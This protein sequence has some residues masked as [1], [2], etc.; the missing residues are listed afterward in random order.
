MS[1]AALDTLAGAYAALDL[2]LEGNNVAHIEASC[3]R[4]R[5]AI[6]GVRA[7]G[8]WQ[9]NPALAKSAAALLG[10]VESTQ[11]HVK[12]LTLDTRERLSALDAARAI[13]R[14][15]LYGRSGNTAQP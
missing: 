5:A 15:N 2:A 12:R 4:F 10:R 8:A 11:Q 14:L 9:S 13:P 1:E 6:F 7:S 3:E